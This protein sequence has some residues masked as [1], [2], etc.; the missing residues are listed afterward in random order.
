MRD[1]IVVT[2][3]TGNVGRKVVD[4][5][6]AR[7]HKVSAVARGAEKLDLL[8]G[9]GVEVRQG[10]L[11][12]KAFLTGVFS[13]A[14]AAFVLCPVDIT[15]KDVN[16]DQRNKIDAIGAAIRQSGLKH[17]VALSSWGLENPEN[18]GAMIGCHWLEKELDAIP[19]LNVVNLRP[20]WFMENFLWNIP[21][22]KMAGINGLS[23]LADLSFPIIATRDVAPVAADYL[24]N[25]NF[26]GRNTHNLNGPG[27]YT[28]VEMTN[29]L[30]ASI[31]R[32]CLGYVKFPEGIFKKGLTGG[33]GLSP[34]AADMLIEIDR[35]I[36]SGRVRAVPRSPTNT[37]G[38]SLE[39]FAK[40][41]FAPAF[42]AAPDAS[43]KDK[44]G[45]LLL[46]GILVA[47]G[48]RTRRACG[49]IAGSPNKDLRP[50]GVS[51]T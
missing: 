35:A 14:K 22:I 24:S 40:T 5:L 16:A 31:G 1:S 38:T 7:G 45:G 51:K 17:V 47:T 36:N 20:V 41:V 43:L 34:N 18:I 42:K 44:M 21:L 33:G 28:L 12:D 49:V 26:T 39:E 25:L 48:N 10:S 9:R 3:A 11:E 15:A 8:V 50:A 32:P 2:G 23:L 27:E 19:G 30:G 13:G 6:S 29:V 4:L 37:T 46:R